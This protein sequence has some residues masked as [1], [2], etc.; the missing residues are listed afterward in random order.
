MLRSLPPIFYW[1]LAF[2]CGLG[3]LAWVAGWF[4]ERPPLATF[5][6]D[7]RDALAGIAAAGPM[8]LGFAVCVRW[9]VGPLGRIRRFS[10]EVIRPLFRPCSITQLGLISVAA[11][12]GE[13]MLFRG[14]LQ[15]LLA[16]W[17]GFWPGVLAAALVFALMHLI[18]LTYAFLAGLLGLYLSV[19]WLT[20]GNL[21]SVVV[22]HALYDFVALVYLV[23]APAR[24]GSTWE[25]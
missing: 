25:E 21:L 18:T 20:N 4:F 6:W 7:V 14:F 5:R 11:G 1:G 15:T 16:D 22:A 17:W 23:K 24:R 10:D 9:P 8:L 12:F 13:E 3:V 2:E 19:V